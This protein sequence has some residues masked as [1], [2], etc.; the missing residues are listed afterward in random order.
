MAGRKLTAKLLIE[1]PADSVFAFVADYRNVPRLLEGVK[2]WRPIGGRSEG[3]G[4]RYLVGLTALG[5]SVEARIRISEWT[6][7]KVIAWVSESSPIENHGSWRFRSRS[8][9]TELSLELDY[10]PPAGGVGNFLAARIEGI[11]RARILKAL[12]DMK[13]ELEAD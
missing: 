4:A 3:V 2:T 9:G 1:R 10:T 7:G 8:G 13:A 11:V 5:F 6:R 12:G